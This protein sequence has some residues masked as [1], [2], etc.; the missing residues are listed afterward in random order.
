MRIHILAILKT[1]ASLSKRHALRFQMIHRPLC[2][3]AHKLSLELRIVGKIEHHHPSSRIVG[4]DHSAQG[5]QM[6]LLMREEAIDQRAQI[7]HRTGQPIEFGHYKRIGI[8][9]L[10]HPKRSL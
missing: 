9:T 8:P 1:K 4:I 3:L 2:P 7:F 5:Q 10:Q 6:E